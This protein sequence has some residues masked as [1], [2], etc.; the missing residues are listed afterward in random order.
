MFSFFK[1]KPSGVSQ[2]N[3]TGGS[4]ERDSKAARG[5]RLWKEGSQLLER[6]RYV[7][8]IEVMRQAQE[9]EPSRLDGRLNLG[10]ALYLIKEYSD[11]IGHLKYVLALEPQNTVALLNLAACYD[12]LGQMEQSIEVL[13]QLVADRPQWKDAHYNLAVAYYKIKLY[14]KAEEALKAELRINPG[15]DAARTLLNKIYL[16]LPQQKRNASGKASH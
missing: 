6:K 5:D 10:A 12:A 1:R 16:M 4:T 15:H 11:A 2:E 9:L 14:D 7:K 3:A 8:A 13:E